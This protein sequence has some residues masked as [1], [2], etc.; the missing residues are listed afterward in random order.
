V[1]LANLAFIISL[2]DDLMRIFG[3]DIKKNMERFGMTEDENIESKFLSR[4]IEQAQEKVEKHNFEIRKHLLEYDDVLNQQ[5]KVIYEYRRSILRVQR[6]FM[7]LMRDLLAAAVEDLMA[8]YA[9]KRT[10][11]EESFEKILEA[12]QSL[13][14]ISIADLRQEGFNHA[15]AERLEVDLIN[16]LLMKYD[17]YRNQLPSDVIKDAEKWLM[18]ETIDQAWKQHMQN[19]DHLKEGIGLRGWG[20]KNPLIE[21]KRE[22]FDM[23][24]DMMRSVRWDIVHHIFHLNVER[25]NHT[26]IEHKRQRELDELQMLSA[27]GADQGPAE[28]SEDKVGRNEQCSCGSGKKYKKCHGK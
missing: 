5:R 6:K 28:R 2:E 3:S 20:Q 15:N 25:F 14:K 11:S 1:I 16:F 18:L 27:A 12:I 26:E 8:F 9:P 10:V 13:T 21:Y 19:L 22:A 23:F 24:Q 7:R 17:L 4:R